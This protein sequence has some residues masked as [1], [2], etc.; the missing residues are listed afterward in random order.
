MQA[1]CLSPEVVR[2]VES[3][4]AILSLL[5]VVRMLLDFA[6]TMLAIECNIYARYGRKDGSGEIS[7][8]K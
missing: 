5:A 7:Y 8:K 1:W 2:A 3:V 4:L 6:S